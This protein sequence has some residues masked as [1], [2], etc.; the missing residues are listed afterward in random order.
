MQ[1]VST[2]PASC[3]VNMKEFIVFYMK[4]VESAVLNSHIVPRAR[5]A[6]HCER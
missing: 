1:G 4:F 6:P 3:R 5:G 2:G